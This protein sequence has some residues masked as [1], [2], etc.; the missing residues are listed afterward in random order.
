VPR[1][2]PSPGPEALHRAAALSLVLLLGLATMLS[3]AAARP[4]VVSAQEPVVQDGD[5]N[6]AGPACPGSEW[7]CEPIGTEPIEQTGSVNV[8]ECVMEQTVAAPGVYAQACPSVTQNGGQNSALIKLTHVN[9]GGSMQCAVQSA[10]VTQTGVTNELKAMFRIVQETKIGPV[11][12]QDAR[13]RLTLLQTALQENKSDV[14]QVQIQKA[15]GNATDQ[16]QNTGC[17]GTIPSEVDC[18]PETQKLSE[19]Y[20]C[21]SIEQVIGFGGASD[22]ISKLKQEVKE[23]AATTVATANQQQ[24][25]INGGNEGRVHQEAPPE[26]KSVDIADQYTYQ[27]LVAP[28][29]GIDANQEQFEDPI[30]CGRSSQVGGTDNQEVINQVVEQL[31]G[32]FAF[33]NATAI[34]EAV[35]PNGGCLI[36]HTVKNNGGEVQE[37]V[38]ADPCPIL[39]LGT[40]CVSA[41]ESDGCFSTCPEGFELDEG[42]ECVPQPDESNGPGIG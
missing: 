10:D 38:S 29:R 7:D 35:S 36:S 37:S 23:E 14:E 2:L 26:G 6:Y 31:A 20:T 15:T 11:Q 13:Q 5:L 1:L 9:T 33:Q 21:A 42:G 41:G 25:T 32:R 27:K 34:G 4:S 22:N 17:G 3:F 28:R 16:E 30:C 39:I 40:E 8:F 18:W 12:E 24:G 19:P